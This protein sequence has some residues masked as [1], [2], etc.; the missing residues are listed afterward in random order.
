MKAKLVILF[1]TL[2]VLSSCKDKKMISNSNSVDTL[3]SYSISNDD[4]YNGI[5]TA[6]TTRGLKLDKI[7]EHIALLYNFIVK[8]KNENRSISS[9]TKSKTV[10]SLRNKDDIVLL[11]WLGDKTIS[12]LSQPIT[13]KNPTFTYILND[14]ELHFL[15]NLLNEKNKTL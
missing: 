11:F 13:P 3:Y 5:F 9:L 10:Y 1:I 12:I 6:K 4:P 15:T 8:I 2:M 7:K 14:E